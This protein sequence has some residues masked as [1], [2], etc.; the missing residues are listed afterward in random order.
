MIIT[1]THVIQGKTITSYLGIVFGQI[2]LGINFEDCEAG[3]TNSF[4]EYSKAYGSNL[5]EARERALRAMEQEAMA[6]GATAI[7]GI[8]IKYEGIGHDRVTMLMVTAFG[9]AVSVS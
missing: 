9:T 5:A 3:F 2:I 6:L 4:S 1:T 8:D 7:V